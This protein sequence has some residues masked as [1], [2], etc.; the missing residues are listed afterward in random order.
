MKSY[1]PYLDGKGM[2]AEQLSSLRVQLDEQT[3]KIRRTFA[4][5]VFDLQKHIEDSN[6]LDD[7]LVV[8][9]FLR[10]KN[11]VDLLPSCSNTI[12]VFDK[13]SP[14]FSFFDF[15]I[16]KLIT[17]KLGSEFNKRK[18]KKYRKMFKEFS[19]QRVCECPK[20]AFGDAKK[21]E[22]VF[23]VKVD[24]DIKSLTVEE[25]EKLKF[26]LCKI[27]NI[28]MRL[29]SVE[30]GCVKLS[31]RVLSEIIVISKKQQ[32][33]LKSFCVLRIQYG[34]E[35]IDISASFY[36]EKV[37]GMMCLKLDSLLIVYTIGSE[38]GD[39]RSDSGFFT[40]EKDTSSNDASKEVYPV[41]TMIPR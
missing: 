39:N 40:K 33:A 22:K 21:S 41:P 10:N 37:L 32:E 7:L 4:S 20:D 8:L 25:L 30:D 24:Q 26:N 36:K 29:L 5:L 18:L 31:F 3:K 28:E 6:K 1:F 9:K 2:S 12:E 23:F 38:G 13:I 17:D 34:K 11:I 14:F 19:K 15:G 35:E 27:L 16:I